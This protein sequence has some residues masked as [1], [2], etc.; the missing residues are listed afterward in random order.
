M[1]KIK[2]YLKR[3]PIKFHF[4]AENDFGFTNIYD[5]FKVDYTSG[6]HVYLIAINNNISQM[7]FYKNM[8][9]NG[10]KILI[11]FNSKEVEI[12]TYEVI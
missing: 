6:K 3:K 8:F 11:K 1:K 12:G 10:G 9:F 7:T 5:S 2:I 4:E